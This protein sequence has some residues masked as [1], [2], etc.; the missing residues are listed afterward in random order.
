MVK[1]TR[2]LTTAWTILVISALVII[3]LPTGGLAQEM[4]WNR[5]FGGPE[6]D[7]G[8]SAQQTQDGGYIILADTASFGAGNFDV[9]LIKTDSSGHKVWD[10][11][12]GGPKEDRGVSALQTPDG[13]YIIAG[14]TGSVEAGHSGVWLIK[15][16]SSGN[17]VWDKTFGGS[18][19]Y[20]AWAHAFQPTSDGGY[21]FTGESVPYESG[22]Y[23]ET[24]IDLWLAKTDALGNEEWERTFGGS[25]S[26]RGF[27]V[28]QTQDGGYIIAGEA[29][30]G[31][32]AWLIKTDASGNKEWDK[33]FDD[34]QVA[35][36]VQQV[37]DGG[38]IVAGRVAVDDVWLMKTDASGNKLWDKTFGGSE[39]DEG[40]S[41]KQTRDGGYIIAGETMGHGGIDHRDVWLVKTD[42]TG[43]K[44][45]DRAF[46]SSDMD[47][48]TSVQQTSDGGYIVAGTRGTSGQSDMWL[49][50]LKGDEEGTGG[51]PFWAWAIIGVGGV[52]VV[53]AIT[54]LTIRARRY[55][56]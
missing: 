1:L 6:N 20:S 55:R 41:V 31:N 23:H 40:Y 30:W 15:A 27:S 39:Y 28:Q 56:V 43:N 16:D 18:E 48:A 34:T 46:G 8:L 51:L 11:T 35:W 3:C 14:M 37:Q 42:A 33:A 29:C 24:G 5:T 54:A 7:W 52:L 17:K 47:W 49:I 50:K 45:W 4:E 2:K 21:I 25:H 19:S 44:Q 26:D 9:W 12:F 53:S 36:S 13:G 32:N 38:Y 10:K 22:E